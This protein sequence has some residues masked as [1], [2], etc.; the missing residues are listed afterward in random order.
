MWLPSKRKKH[1]SQ[2]SLPVAEAGHLEH[3]QPEAT[4]TF[5]SHFMEML[6]G[7]F[8]RHYCCCPIICFSSVISSFW[9]CFFFRFPE[10]IS[11]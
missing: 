10:E 9:I 2:G 1:Y 8:G 5:L 11:V 3:S 4:G 6:F 7:G